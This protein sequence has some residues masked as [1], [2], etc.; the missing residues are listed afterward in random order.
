MMIREITIC[1]Y[2]LFTSECYLQ[3]AGI[4]WRGMEWL[5]L[6]ISLIIEHVH[7]K[8]AILFA[9]ESSFS[10]KTESQDAADEDS[11]VVAGHT[12]DSLNGDSHHLQNSSITDDDWMNTFIA[13]VLSFFG[14]S[15][16][17]IADIS[18][19]AI[20]VSL[21]DLPVFTLTA[22]P[23]PSPA[24]FCLWVHIWKLTV[25]LFSKVSWE[26][27]Q[28]DINYLKKLDSKCSKLR[29]VIWMEIHMN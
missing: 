9:F 7:L 14:V 3:Q 21:H 26:F 25:T 19:T 8:G 13:V 18:L 10:I 2:S 24:N 22:G 16:P 12:G 28:I 4:E 29:V 20:V 5:G 6:L 17:R 23:V 15:N 27:S 1:P 11:S